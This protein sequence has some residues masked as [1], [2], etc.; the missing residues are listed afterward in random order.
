[1]HIYLIFKHFVILPCNCVFEKLCQLLII[2]GDT[3]SLSP[4]NEGSGQ[5]ELLPTAGGVEGDRHPHESNDL[6]D[7]AA[8]ADHHCPAQ[9]DE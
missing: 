8:S 2:S 5:D 3:G 9:D 7:G 6:D 1:M 4:S